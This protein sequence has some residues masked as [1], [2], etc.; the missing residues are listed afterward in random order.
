M[1]TAILYFLTAAV[2]EEQLAR[3]LTTTRVHGLHSR[4]MMALM[5]TKKK[6]PL[7]LL[8]LPSASYSIRISVKDER[9][10]RLFL[11]YK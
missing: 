10:N 5:M 11:V 9:K 8:Q 2:V 3:H 7:P 1:M 4:P 6:Q